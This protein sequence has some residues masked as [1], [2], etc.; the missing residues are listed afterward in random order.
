MKS[1]ARWMR[2]MMVSLRSVLLSINF[3]LAIVLIFLTLFAEV[4]VDFFTYFADYQ[5]NHAM[6]AAYPLDLAIRFGFFRY[7]APLAAAFASG[8]KLIDDT[9]GGF[10]RL[11]LM[12]SGKH[13]YSLGLFV[14]SSIGGGLAVA[15]GMLLCVILCAVHYGVS[16]DIEGLAY[17]EAWIPLTQGQWR[18]MGM[19]V[20]L[21]FLFGM[22]WSG[23]GLLISVYSPVRYVSYLSPFMICF[24]AALVLPPQVQPLEMLV[25]SQWESFTFPKMFLYQGVL[26]LVMMCWFDRAVERKIIYEW[27]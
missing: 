16:A 17:N 2:G 15:L 26:Y 25:P 19:N 23:A 27:N 12:K 24:A 8:G 14:G 18:Y 7:A 3:Y 9:E 4:S 6:G 21:T 10:H 11:R 1:I 22:V 5:G 20:L 13:E